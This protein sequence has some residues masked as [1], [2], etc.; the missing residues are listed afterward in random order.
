[1]RHLIRTELVKLRTTRAPLAV[2]L[3]LFALTALITPFAMGDIGQGDATKA[4]DALEVLA[5]GPGLITALV[6]LLLGA[7]AAAGEF[8]HRT[9]VTTYL[10]TPRRGRILVAKLL[11]H[12]ALGAVVAG[13]GVAITFP[14]VLVMAN[15]D[16]LEV[17]TTP[18]LFGLAAAI[19]GVGALASVFGVA[20]GSILRNQTAVILVILLW[21]LLFERFF[22]GFL[23]P[24]L[25]FGAILT[26]AGLAG[27]DAPST[28]ASFAVLTVWA[29]A[30]ILAAQQYFIR[31]DVT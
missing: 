15:A 13:I 1:M 26:A 31:R 25:P 23:P 28:L 12:G 29:G 8:H 4:D 19:V 3:G 24:I 18:E 21:T 9:I 2:L 14:I 6:L 16:G 7:I 17:A 22:G 5:V 11:T 10:I 20:A 27:D 30:L